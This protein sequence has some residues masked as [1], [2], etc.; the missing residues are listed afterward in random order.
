MRPFLL[1]FLW[2]KV[3]AKPTDEGCWTERAGVDFERDPSPEGPHSFQHPSSD[4]AFGSAT[5]SHKGRRK[6]LPCP[7][8]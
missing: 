8:A 2:E 3:S 1:P 6:A 7:T 5:F 4:L